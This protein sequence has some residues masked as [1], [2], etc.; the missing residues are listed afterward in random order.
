M[1]NNSYQSIS[2]GNNITSGK[3]NDVF[4]GNNIGAIGNSNGNNTYVGSSIGF[5]AN[6]GG[7]YYNAVFG[8]R[9]FGGFGAN[10]SVPSYT[11]AFGYNLFSGVYFDLF[12]ITIGGNNFINLNGN[13]NLGSTM[14][15]ILPN[16]IT[17]HNI[18]IGMNVCTSISNVN[19]SIFIDSN[20]SCVNS[21]TNSVADVL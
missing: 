21:I 9:V 5:N 6:G 19:N 1:F 12:N 16:R 17:Q 8:N 13:N 11:Y 4:I 14:N 3:T 10:S 15:P 2:I 7:G 18:G 20:T